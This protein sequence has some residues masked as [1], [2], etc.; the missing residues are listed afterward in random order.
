MAQR[1]PEAEFPCLRYFLATCP[2]D[3]VWP[4]AVIVPARANLSKAGARP[5]ARSTLRKGQDRDEGGNP[6]TT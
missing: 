2:S 3:A 5:C 1:F 4:G 6:R